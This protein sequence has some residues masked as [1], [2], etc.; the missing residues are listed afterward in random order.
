MNSQIR[1]KISEKNEVKDMARENKKSNDSVV[2]NNSLIILKRIYYTP[3]IN[4]Y[5]S[6][7]VVK[8]VVKVKV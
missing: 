2:F 8:I 6:S 7:K 3:C 1:I 5:K 4:V